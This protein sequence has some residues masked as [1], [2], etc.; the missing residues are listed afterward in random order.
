MAALARRSAC[1]AGAPCH[2]WTTGIRSAW[3]GGRNGSR[4]GRR[5]RGRRRSGW[6]RTPCRRSRKCGGAPTSVMAFGKAVVARTA[7]GSGTHVAPGAVLRGAACSGRTGC[8]VGGRVRL[9]GIGRR[10]SAGGGGEAGWVGSTS[11]AVAFL[12]NSRSR[13]AGSL[14]DCATYGDGA[15][16]RSR[17]PALVSVGPGQVHGRAIGVPRGLEDW[18][19]VGA[20]L[21]ARALERGGGSFRGSSVVGVGS[22][23]YLE[24]RQSFHLRGASGQAEDSVGGRR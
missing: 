19:P 14:G 24:A 9:R 2:L 13:L 12:F 5:T 11:R 23:G 17:A 22:C 8:F 15:R 16:L 3:A 10:G 18:V 1:G 4:S 20:G 21:V 7:T 6:P